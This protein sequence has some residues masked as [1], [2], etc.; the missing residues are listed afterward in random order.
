MFHVKRG[1][2]SA[3]CPIERQAGRAPRWG[4]KRAEESGHRLETDA[5]S[6]PRQLD[7]IP[8]HASL[9][10]TWRSGAAIA[11]SVIMAMPVDW[12]CR[13]KAVV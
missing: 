2:A 3:P 11:P 10:A 9:P 5:L 7:C 8:V 1:R 4:D 13:P 6:S 12:R